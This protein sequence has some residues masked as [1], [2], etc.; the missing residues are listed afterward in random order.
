MRIKKLNLQNFMGYDAAH[1]LD[2]DS[3][4]ILLVGENGAGKTSLLEGLA[5]ALGIWHATVLGYGWRNISED[6]IRR[7]WV[8]SNGAR[9]LEKQFPVEVAVEGEIGGQELKWARGIYKGNK[10][11]NKNARKA[12]D[13]IE[14]LAEKARAGEPVSLPLV[15]YYGDGRLHLDRQVRASR[16]GKENPKRVQNR[17]S[18]FEGN[19][20][21]LDS[22]IAWKDLVQWVARQEWVTFQ[23]KQEPVE[24][25][26]FKQ[27]ILDCLEGGESFGYDARSE[28]ILVG[29]QRQGVLPLENLSAGQKSMVVMIG[30]LVR[31]LALLNPHLGLEVAHESPGIVLIDELDLHLHPVWQRKIAANLKRTFRQLQFIC[32]SHSPQIIGEL[33]PE[34]VRLLQGKQVSQPA[35]SF[36]MDSNWILKVLMG[37]VEMDP[38]IKGDIKT[39]QELALKR[40][41]PQARTLLKSLRERVGNSKEI[42]FAASTIDRVELLGK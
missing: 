27:A 11:S 7:G 23:E 40:E 20:N 21:S 33:Q 24:Y 6:H 19:R 30:D 38:E 15:A 18:R 4:F 12:Q 8:G 35:Q 36:G 3:K 2:F 1:D 42:Q 13:I 5:D 17:L 39:V 26:V 9:S 16:G 25:K 10:T 29:I 34:E 32:T 28:Q 22:R 41:F 14:S 31:R 37:G